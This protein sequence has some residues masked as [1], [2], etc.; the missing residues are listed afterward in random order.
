MATIFQEDKKVV[1]IGEEK[2]LNGD[3]KARIFSQLGNLHTIDV[4]DVYT[5]FSGRAIEM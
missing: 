4:F 1:G 2:W 3:G 5:A